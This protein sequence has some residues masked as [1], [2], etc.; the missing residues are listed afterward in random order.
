MSNEH[1]QTIRAGVDRLFALYERGNGPERAGAY[2]R[3]LIRLS[4]DRLERAIT[5]AERAWE[6]KS[7][8]PVAWLL[9]AA[10]SDAPPATDAGS[11]SAEEEA[12][13]ERMKQLRYYLERFSMPDWYSFREAFGFPVTAALYAKFGLT[14][15]AGVRFEPPHPDW[16]EEQRELAARDCRAAFRRL[17]RAK[18]SAPLPRDAEPPF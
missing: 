1:E 4:I 18:S 15:P 3:A 10:W 5:A 12:Q 6:Q 16:C 2:T 11:L 8:P 14:A 13:S 7:P 9:K 17:E